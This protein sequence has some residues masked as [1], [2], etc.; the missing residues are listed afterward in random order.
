M[1]NKVVAAT[2][3]AAAV[4]ALG[5]PAVPAAS[6]ADYP[7]VRA[8]VYPSYQDARAA[9]FDGLHGQVWSS[10]QYRQQEDTGFTELWVSY[11]DGLQPPPDAPGMTV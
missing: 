4:V 10:C 1:I 7:L 9:C 8:G 6:A 11:E 2:A 5:A 3:L